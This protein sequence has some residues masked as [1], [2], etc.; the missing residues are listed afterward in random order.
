MTQFLFDQLSSGQTLPLG[1]TDTILFQGGPARLA[2][3]SFDID[4]ATISFGGHFATFG[5]GPLAI[6]SVQQHLLF[7][8]GS[9]LLIG[10]FG[11]DK[12]DGGPLDDGLFGALGNDTL[13]GPAGNNLLQGNQGDDVLVG[14]DG[15]DTIFGGQGS[16][17]LVGDSTGHQ[18]LADFDVK[19]D[20]L[21]GNK[22]DDTITG[23][24]ARDTLLGGQ[25][26]DRIT[27]DSGDF[28][29]GNLGD[30]VLIGVGGC[31]LLGE[32]GADTLIAQAISD[33]L[34]GGAGA[35]LFE[36][37]FH[38]ETA[39]FGPDGTITDWESQDRLSVAGLR[40]G[41]S[42]QTAT[43]GDFAQALV[44]ANGLMHTGG[45]VVVVQVGG[46]LI[47]FFQTDAD[48]DAD[49][50]LTLTGRALADISAANFI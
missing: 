22:G 11:D 20:F 15:A 31:H 10:A 26:N 39:A 35:D 5:L 14:E 37:T 42:V 2:S 23:S 4:E 1:S 48:P 29:N 41:F 24:D 27:A 13:N 7:D 16:D 38:R 25:G 6:A 40:A 32:D 47:A 36:F 50:A 44:A 33:T 18:L 34:S 17:L 49:L 19:G 30:D 46:D 45:D 12:L 9:H 43:A 8:D 21:Q 28:A 3:V